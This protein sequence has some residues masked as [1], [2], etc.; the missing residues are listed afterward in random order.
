MKVIILGAC[1]GMGRFVA[2]SVSSFEEVDDLAIADLILKEEKT[3][4]GLLP[5]INKIS[6]GANIHGTGIDIIIKN[7]KN[8]Y[9]MICDTDIIITMKNW[10]DY[11]LSY[12]NDKQIYIFSLV[13]F[14]FL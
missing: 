9:I 13:L 2:K 5:R 11:M 3:F 10:D 4:V 1:G 7:V 12:L 8:K 6:G 14:K